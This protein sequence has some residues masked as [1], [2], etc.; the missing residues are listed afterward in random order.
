M[1]TPSL[2]S[3]G[4]SP[5]GRMQRYHPLGI[6]YSQV[7]VKKAGPCTQMVVFGIGDGL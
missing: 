7:P 3:R 1:A 2:L 6:E 4:L 5:R